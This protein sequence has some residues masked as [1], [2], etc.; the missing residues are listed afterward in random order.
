MANR[1]G[2]YAVLS[3]EP[4]EGRRIAWLSLHS[5]FLGTFIAFYFSAANGL[6]L[7]QFKASALPAAYIVSGLAGYVTVALFSLLERRLSAAALP[8][9]QLGFLIALVTALWGAA[10]VT[11][12]RWAA[13]AMFVAITP[14]FTVLNLEFWGLATRLFDLRQGKRLFG[15]L[16]CGE[17]VSS[18]VG[19][20][21]V[22]LILY[23]LAD[24][25]ILLPFAICGLGACM[26]I[27][28]AMAGRFPGALGGRPEARRT[29]PPLRLAD[30]CRNRYF[31]LIA[32][33][34]ATSVVANYLVDFSFLSMVRQRFPASEQVAGFIGIFFGVTK[35]IELL[36][37][38]VVAGRLLTAFG[39]RFGLAA[40]PLTLLLCAT[41]A[42]LAGAS[43]GPGALFFL[44]VVLAKLVWLVLRK[45]LFDPSLRVLF[46]PLPEGERLAFQSRLEGLVQQLSTGLA[47]LL[48]L[49]LA[50]G[51][52][53]GPLALLYALLPTL[54]ACLAVVGALHHEYRARLLRNLA[55][56][57]APALTPKQPAPEA[58]EPTAPIDAPTRDLLAAAAA[59]AAALSEAAL[60]ELE[61]AFVRAR[62]PETRASIL[63][64]CEAIGGPRAQAFLI[65]QLHFPDRSIALQ[66]LIA[67]TE[68][69]V[70]AAPGQ[71]HAVKRGIEE[72]AEMAAW[73]SAALLD[74]AGESACADTR[75]S[76]E[77]DLRGYRRSL[78]RL[79]SLLCDPRAV[80]LVRDSLENGSGASAVYA[81]EIVDL[82]VPADIKP[83]VLPWMESL[84]PAQLL[85]RLEGFTVPRRLAPVDRLC[86]ILH[87]ERGTLGVWTKACAIHALGA[88]CSEVRPDLV[89]VLFHPDPVLQEAAAEAIFRIDPAAYARHVRKLL[90]EDRERLD[91]LVGAGGGVPALSAFARACRLRTSRPF[92]TLPAEAL[93]QLATAASERRLA[94]GE[95]SAPPATGPASLQVVLAGRLGGAD[96]GE[97][98][99]L[100]R[101]TPRPRAEEP[102]HLLALEGERFL[103]AVARFPSVATA[104]AC[105]RPRSA[106]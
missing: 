7:A 44:L 26:L 65:E 89:A 31:L 49:A 14:C 57:G 81:L 13:F 77:K 69:G 85:S 38:S 46:Q 48:L 8:L 1:R 59:P 33:L 41:G 66:A 35:V 11:G 3:I 9:W 25:L 30:L 72:L 47:G 2:L 95:A 82:L 99:I 36:M 17:V 15:L 43:M 74:L 6:F 29:G 91:A 83:L 12:S 18:L 92:A 42:A 90:P 45:S 78:Y 40:L 88:L 71:E 62:T 5:L 94:P 23:F 4:G 54:A 79:L 64:A 24:P 37:K 97:A 96:P 60:P 106:W 104:V 68:R 61:A 27:V 80:H 20:F 52:P 73:C 34:L 70:R 58:P 28:R 100:G 87:R 105:Y 53:G 50:A 67:L 101:A 84:S 39:L 102:T 56:A 19:Y 32:A 51:G 103:A 21:L 98:V 75:A 63:R 93:L 22:P 76:L 16:G 55:Q 86:A 10:V